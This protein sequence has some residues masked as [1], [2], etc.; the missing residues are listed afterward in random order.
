MD[1]RRRKGEQV[2]V[3]VKRTVW[4]NPMQKHDVI[5]WLSR[6]VLCLLKMLAKEVQPPEIHD[7][8]QFRLLLLLHRP[9]LDDLVIKFRGLSFET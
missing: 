7:S 3:L 4:K 2:Y 8:V 6:V 5:S 1:M 9:I